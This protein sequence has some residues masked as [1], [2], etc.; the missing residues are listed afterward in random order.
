MSTIRVKR[1]LA[2]NMPTTGLV[3]G[4]FLFATDTGD[5]YICQTSTEKILLGKAVDQNNYLLKLENLDD[6]PN[7]AAARANLGVYSTIEVDQLLA[8]LRWKN[9]C[10]VATVG[11]ITLSGTQSVNGVSLAVGDRVLVRT[12]TDAKTNGIYVVSAG[13]W[14][15][16]PDADSSAE[17]LNAAVFVSQGSQFADT[18]WVCTT[19][20][21]SLGSSN[22]DF[23]QF[24]GVSTYT[25]G[26]GIDISGNSIDLNLDELVADTATASDDLLIFIDVSATGT[27]RYKKITRQNFLSGLN[28]VSDTYQVKVLSA[29]TPGFLDDVL[30]LTEGV[31]KNSAGNAMTIRL[32][33]N[34]LAEEDTIDASLDMVPIYDAS[35]NGH[36][37]TDVNDLIKNATIDGGTF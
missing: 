17:L 3:P 32:D 4:E 26:Y 31:R 9:P 22:L 6:V 29:S 18:A 34:G 27:A 16:S 21:I 11:N 25:G 24:A 12:Q 8:G 2:A 5:L 36:R 37:R 1:G 23:V 13:A 14:S 28:L 19:D 15:R 33:V 20:D 35:A 10:R 7:K 30:T